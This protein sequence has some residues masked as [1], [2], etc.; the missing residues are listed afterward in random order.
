[1]FDDFRQCTRESFFDE[2]DEKFRDFQIDFE[3]ENKLDLSKFIQR[4]D[5]LEEKIVM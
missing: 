2:L 3:K 5:Q 4:I 1:M